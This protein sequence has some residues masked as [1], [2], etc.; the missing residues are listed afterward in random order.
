MKLSRH[1]AAPYALAAFFALIAAAVWA[2]FDPAAGLALATFAGADMQTLLKGLD[3]IETKLGQLP[4]LADRVFQLEQKGVTAPDPGAASGNRTSLGSLVW[5]ELTKNAELLEKTKSVR[6]V[7]K[8]ATDPIGTTGVRNI[9]VGGVGAPG[10]N[11]VGIQN[12]LRQVPAGGTSAMEYSRYTGKEGGAA[13]QATEGAAKSYIRPTHSLITQKALTVAGLTKITRQAQSD[14]RELVAAIDNIL[15]REVFISADVLLTN[16]GTDFSGG[17]EGL[18][19][20]Y[21]SLVYTALVD[22]ISEGVATMQLAGFAPD[23]V[24]LN[25]TDWL[26]ITVAKGT[27]NDH[28][29]SGS[30]LGALPMEMRTLRVVLSPSID[31][32]KALL[33]DSAHSELGVVDQFTVE[34][35]YSSDDFEKNLATMRGEM[36]VIPV[37]RTAGSLRFI[38]PK[39]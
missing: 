31:A 11:L 19:T 26:A 18:A 2:L 17:F 34:I 10:A 37:M 4:E 3:K 30:Y 28:Y 33:M 22:A 21:T 6:L 23:V 24:V 32:G 12:A 16:G 38:T 1:P 20:T 15:M 14:R 35:A 27:S 29:L 5:D 39:A 25:P 9:R 7:I 8:A 13:Q 36:R